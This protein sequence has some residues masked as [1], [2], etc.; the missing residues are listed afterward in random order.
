PAF[1]ILFRCFERATIN[2]SE[3]TKTCVFAK[4]SVDI[5][6]RFLSV[7]FFPLF[8]AML[9]FSGELL[10]QNPRPT[11]PPDEDTGKLKTFEVRLPVTVTLKKE[12]ITGLGRSD[13]AVFEDGVPQEVTFFTDEKSNPPV[14]VGSLR[15][16]APPAAGKLGFS[17]EAAMNFMHTV[18]R[19]RKDRAAFMTFDNQ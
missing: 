11:P 5:M 3:A 17:K 1:D 10:A 7:I 14:Y 2:R 15:D 18:L 13:F 6:N 9:A 16:T 12:L 19:L 8:V 4:N